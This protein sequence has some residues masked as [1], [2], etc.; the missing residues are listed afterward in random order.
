M[1]RRG[2]LG[3]VSALLCGEPRSRR[4]DELEQRAEKLIKRLES[5]LRAVNDHML[6]HDESDPRYKK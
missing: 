2:F 6:S 4:L 5:G 1:Q 3:I